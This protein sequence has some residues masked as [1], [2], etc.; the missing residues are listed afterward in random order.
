M[1]HGFARLF[2]GKASFREYYRA[3]SLAWVISW[4]QAVPVFGAIVSLW[5]LPVNVLVLK[6]GSARWKRRR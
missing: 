6:S 4:A 2:G 3:T 5:S 1:F